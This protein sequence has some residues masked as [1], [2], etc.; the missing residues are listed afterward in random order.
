MDLTDYIYVFMHI[1]SYMCNNNSSRIEE[2][3]WKGRSEM[4][5][6]SLKGLI[7]RAQESTTHRIN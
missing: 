5:E 1:H 4:I 7:V 6:L 2:K 3:T